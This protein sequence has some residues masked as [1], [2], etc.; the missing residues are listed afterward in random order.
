M[1]IIRNTLLIALAIIA[2]P[3]LTLC[4]TV[5]QTSAQEAAAQE[6]LKT[7]REQ[8]EAYLQRDIAKIERLVADEFIFTNGRDIGNKKTLIGFLRSSEIDPTLTLTT[9]DTRVTIN[10]D[11]A[12]VIGRRVER[13]RREDNNREGVAYARYVRTYIKRQEHWQLLAEHLETI[14]G[15]RT[16]VKIDTKVYDDYVGQYESAIFDFE[17][18][19][20]GERLMAV[21]KERTTTRT[22]QGRPPAELFP[23]SDTEFFLKGRDAQVIFIR[24][25][26]GEVTH[27]IMRINGADIRGHA[28]QIANAISDTRLSVNSFI[29]LVRSV[30]NSF[31][32]VR[33]KASCHLLS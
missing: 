25:R 29:D 28:C 2:V 12:I 23:E 21:P 26:K 14:P 19:K 11:T 13:R 33:Q 4:Q 17:V 24:N 18:V 15:E 5:S 30:E 20:D 31:G 7:E 22:S 6:V 10:G 32:V 9:E 16:A 27:A 8:R 1:L 3:G